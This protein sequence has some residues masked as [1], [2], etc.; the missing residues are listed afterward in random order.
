MDAKK[1]APALLRLLTAGTF[2]GAHAV[3]RSFGKHA[4]R[5]AYITAAQ[6]ARNLGCP[7]GD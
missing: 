5:F 1:R 7:A 6:F 3:L 2:A 4:H